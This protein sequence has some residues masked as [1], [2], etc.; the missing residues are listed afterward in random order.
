MDA[1]RGRLRPWHRRRVGIVLAA[2]AVAAA[3][4]PVRGSATAAPASTSAYDD[5]VFVDDRADPSRPAFDLDAAVRGRAADPAIASAVVDRA[6]QA[7][8]APPMA[9]VLLERAGLLD[10]GDVSPSDVDDLFDSTAAAFY[11]ARSLDPTVSDA[12][13]RAVVARLW[14][15]ETGPDLPAFQAAYA[16]LVGEPT[17]AETDTA[18]DTVTVAGGTAQ[19]LPAI[20]FLALP[21]TEGAAWSFNGVHT[22]S[23][24]NDGTPMSSIDAS[25]NWP[26]WGTSTA[27]AVV[28]AAHPGVVT[29]YST[30][31]IRVTAANGW[32]TNYY[33][34]SSPQVTN[35][36]SVARGTALAVYADNQSQALCQGG[37]STG[38][39]TH[40]SLLLNGFQ[41]SIDGA[42]FGGWLIHA[43]RYSYDSDTGFMWVER[44]GTRKYAYQSFTNVACTLSANPEGL[45]ASAPGGVL[46]IT[47]TTAADCPWELVLP[48]G[49][50]WLHASGPLT[51]VGSGSVSVS[52]DVNGTGGWRTMSMDF[53]IATIRL[54]QR[55]ADLPRVSAAAVSAATVATRGA[56]PTATAPIVVRAAAPHA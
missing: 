38:P 53:G 1:H 17:L 32:A 3:A 12:G 24:S 2:L 40:V 21:W 26:V 48:A 34:L 45:V 19:G 29:V 14:P 5:R 16:A 35:G 10:R 9:F 41:H 18:S 11:R 8:I 51:G 55:P 39:H 37:S 13:L 25:K 4:F 52:V 47:V 54:D 6:G 20:G 50:T 27:D 42:V 31:N 46:T 15:T 56:T 30:C 28:R 22:T 36:Q 49:A 33:H 44:G 23:G 7:S 43:G